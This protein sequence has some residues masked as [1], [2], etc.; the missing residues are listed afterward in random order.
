MTNQLSSEIRY[1]RRNT[2]FCRI[3]CLNTNSS[4]HILSLPVMIVAEGIAADDVL[5]LTITFI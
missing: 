5:T 4:S 3:D 1:L 2:V